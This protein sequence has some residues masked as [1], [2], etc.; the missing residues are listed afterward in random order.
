MIKRLIALMFLAVVQMPSAVLA[1]GA[2]Q[3][4]DVRAP[5]QII[6]GG[7][8][9]TLAQG[10]PVS[11]GDVIRTGASGRVQILFP[12]D[13]KIVVGP[14]S[15]LKIDQTLFRAN[16]TA[17]KFA[18]SAVGGSFR[19]ISGKSAKSVYKLATPVATMGIRG[20]AFDFTV[21]AGQST[22][23]LVFDGLVRFCAA[24]QQCASVPGGCQAVTVERGGA[25]SQPESAAEKQA[26]LNRR[27]PLLSEQSDLQPPFRAG[28]SR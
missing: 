17:R 27:F 18:A 26:L 13:T 12:D 14:N 23:L 24:G 16:G 19:F 25:F 4:V 6:S 11:S 7:A 5:A 8:T 28:T 10:N 1:Q 22:D 21:N 20:T 15:S 3:V 9:R 2:G